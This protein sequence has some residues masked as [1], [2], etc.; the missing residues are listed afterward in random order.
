M[1]EHQGG[2]GFDA[3]GRLLPPADPFDPFGEQVVADLAAGL[4]APV[5]AAVSESD[6]GQEAEHR[7]PMKL[8]VRAWLPG[9]PGSL[10][11]VL[12]ALGQLGV[13]VIEIELDK[14]GGG[15]DR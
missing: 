2:H 8:T 12:D 3:E 9:T 5:E 7:P 11:R 1:S 6:E 10:N 15:G 13:D 4:R 14:P